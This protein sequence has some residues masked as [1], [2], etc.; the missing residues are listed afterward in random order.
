[1]EPVSAALLFRLALD[2]D[3]AI[4]L[5]TQNL[6]DYIPET[7][8]SLGEV[9]AYI[10]EYTV[11]MFVPADQEAEILA[12]APN[13]IT[14]KSTKLHVKYSH[15]SAYIDVP[16]KLTR[17]I[18]DAI[19]ELG[20]RPVYV[21][22]AKSKDYHLLQDVNVVSIVAPTH[23]RRK[24]HEDQKPNVPFFAHSPSARS[25]QTR[26]AVAIPQ[27]RQPFHAGGFNRASTGRR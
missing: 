6:H 12:S 19:P 5:V 23:Q 25:L 27:Q 13:T 11:N 22:K 21:R 1:V 14:I 24:K 18:P 9:D 17:S 20:D 10:P 2:I 3:T 16:Q 8:R 15:G 4:E 26:K 7:V